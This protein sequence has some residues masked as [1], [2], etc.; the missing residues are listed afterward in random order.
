MPDKKAL[1]KSGKGTPNNANQFI[2]ITKLSLWLP[3]VV[4]L[5][6]QT[7]AAHAAGKS[8]SDVYSGIE[9]ANRIV[10][11]LLADQLDESVLSGVQTPISREKAA[12]PMH[13]YELHV[14]TLAELYHYALKNDRRPPP[15]AVSTPIAYTPTD[16][17]QLT[18]LITSY[19]RE[20]YTE[21]I[22][23]LQI[24]P[25]AHQNK[26]PGEVYQV[27][28][29]LY[30][31]LN[32]LNGKS[33]ISPDEVFAQAQRAKEDLQYSLLTLSKRLPNTEEEKKRLLVT[34]IYGMHPNGSTLAN[35]SPGRKPADVLRKAFDVREKLNLLRNKHQL[36]E[37]DIPGFD[38]YGQVKPIDVFLQTQFIIAELNLLKSPL[39]ITS[40]TNAAKPTSG[41]TP[42]DVYQEMSHIEYM[43]DRLAKVL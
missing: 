12:K 27:L 19:L 8:P 42:T 10:D 26:T 34:S 33:R 18:R 2:Q 30:F 25:K 37:L 41:M 32:L 23:T 21:K 7:L 24:Y 1:R 13:V 11:E 31:K 36:P 40:T 14:S 43:L 28:F 15:I 39:Q 4:T 29:E 35:A 20:L 38:Q 17:F 3:L 22:D 9:Y 5:C 16:V 6:F